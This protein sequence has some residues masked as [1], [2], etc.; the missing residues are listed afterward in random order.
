MHGIHVNAAA[1]AALGQMTAD[2]VQYALP[3]ETRMRARPHGMMGPTLAAAYQQHTHAERPRRHTGRN[4][5]CGGM[6]VL[7]ASSSNNN[8]RMRAHQ[9]RRQ[10]KVTPW[11]RSMHANPSAMAGT[12]PPSST[13]WAM[14]AA[15]GMRCM[16]ACAHRSRR[17]CFEVYRYRHRCTAFSTHGAV[18]TDWK[19]NT[20][21]E[22]C[23]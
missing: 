20:K 11:A 22:K 2:Y 6:G 14:T 23:K 21:H 8:T 7:T 9:A 12:T 13:P 4:T 15:P 1:A 5:R 3:H 10:P 17:C 16:H 19:G 18:W